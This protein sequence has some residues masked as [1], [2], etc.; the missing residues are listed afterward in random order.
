MICGDPLK[1]KRGRSRNS[2]GLLVVG[3]RLWV[4]GYGLKRSACNVT[5]FWTRQVGGIVTKIP[6]IVKLVIT[7]TLDG[8]RTGEPSPY[9]CINN[10]KIYYNRQPMADSQYKG[11]M[12]GE[13]G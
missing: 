1:G 2:C 9:G 12:D 11:E 4:I 8:H 6:L 13:K 3:Y 7:C 5:L 10:S